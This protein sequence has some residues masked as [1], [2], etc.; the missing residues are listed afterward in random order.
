ML[1]LAVLL[2]Q[3]AS[4]FNINACADN[5]SSSANLL[6]FNAINKYH[7]LLLYV[8]TLGL[9]SIVMLTYQ[10]LN[11]YKTKSSALYIS[12]FTTY[13]MLIILTTMYAGS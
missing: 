4:D 10:P 5:I 8:A 1:A 12:S 9:I 13:I 3:L 7:P 6:L 2:T 11:I